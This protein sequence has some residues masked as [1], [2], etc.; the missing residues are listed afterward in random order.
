MKREKLKRFLESVES[1]KEDSINIE[2]K[3]LVRQY[4]GLIIN[5]SVEMKSKFHNTPLD[6]DDIKNI[7]TF[8]LF[9]LAKEFD[10]DKGMEFATFVKAFLS[11]RTINVMKSF[12][13]QKHIVMNQRVDVNEEITVTNE[14]SRDF[15]VNIIDIGEDELTETEKIILKHIIEGYSVTDIAKIL[16]VSKQTVS[17][18]K[19]NIGKRLAQKLIEQET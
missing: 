10:I 1:G 17:R 19:I 11:L 16:G 14:S 3:D 4:E 13:T 8:Q 9:K 15:M 7:V 6:F 12:I 2:F 18:H 5:V